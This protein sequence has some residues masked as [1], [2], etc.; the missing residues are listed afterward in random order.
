MI[1]IFALVSV[2]LIIET[3]CRKRDKSLLEVLHPEWFADVTRFPEHAFQCNTNCEVYDAVVRTGFEKMKTT[4]IVFAGLCINIEQNV[5]LLIQRLEYLGSWFADYKVVIFEN[6]SSDNT[7]YLLLD[8]QKKNPRV[9][10][11]ECPEDAMCKLKKASAVQ[12]GTMSSGRM[13]KM[14]DYRN[15]VLRHI[16]ETSSDFDCVMLLDLDIR[17]PISLRGL[18]SSFGTYNAWDSVSAFGLNGIS[19][20][21]GNPVYYD[22][23]AYKDATLDFNTN[24]LHGL[25]ILNKMLYTKRGGY[26]I[27]VSS[28]F[29]GVALYKMEV[30]RA[31]VNYTPQDNQYVCEHIIFHANMKHAGFTRIFIN[32]NMMV[33]VGP[34][35]D[36]KSYPFY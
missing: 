17:G 25:F 3:F 27:P 11:L 7:R 29:A 13:R 31:D 15:R 35:G 23:I 24:L 18:A 5:P 1:L 26:L 32:P 2:I 21:G 4:R 19:F 10:I 36:V 16:K 20:T 22:L 6:D 8:W 14:V 9:H 34:Q 33:L 12:D 28:G 30:I